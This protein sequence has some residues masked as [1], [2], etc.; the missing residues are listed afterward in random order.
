M[1][2]IE[3]QRQEMNKWVHHAYYDDTNYALSEAERMVSDGKYQGVRVM[4]DVFTESSAKAKSKYLFVSTAKT[5]GEVGQDPFAGAGPE[6]EAEAP[7]SSRKTG[8]KQTSIPVLLGILVALVAAGM[9][10]L[11]GIQIFFDG[12]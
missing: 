8:K 1:R 6:R 3:I 11:A 4:E 9:A 5:R 2:S 10:A 12:L 7:S